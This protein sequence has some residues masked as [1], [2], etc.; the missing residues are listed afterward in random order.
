MGLWNIQTMK[1]T[2]IDESTQCWGQWFIQRLRFSFGSVAGY[3][4]DGDESLVFEFLHGFL[5]KFEQEVAK[6]SENG[7]FVLSIQIRVISE[8]G[9]KNESTKFWCFIKA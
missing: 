4:L 9:I 1:E 3:I 7:V 8:I 5:S 6:S 2:E